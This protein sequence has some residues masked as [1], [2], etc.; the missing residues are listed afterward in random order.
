MRLASVVFIRNGCIV[1]AY[2][3]GDL[4]PQW[5][6]A[7]RGESKTYGSKMGGDLNPQW[8]TASRGGR[9]AKGPN[10]G[11]SLRVAL[12]A[13]LASPYAS[14]PPRTPS[15]PF[16]IPPQILGTPH[17][18]SALFYGIRK[19][20]HTRTFSALFLYAEKLG[21][22]NGGKASRCARLRWILV[23]RF[24]RFMQGHK[25]G[26]LF[27]KPRAYV[28]PQLPITVYVLALANLLPSIRQANI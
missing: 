19:T 21:T 25:K 24:C 10:D 8:L 23:S 28:Y 27:S 7:S 13:P 3:R 4:N 20:P 5:L 1:G 18:L 26:H 15:Q 9:C 14:T 22:H 17:I 11:G 16:F 12:I 6:T 2:P